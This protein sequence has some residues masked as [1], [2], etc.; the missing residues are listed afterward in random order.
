MP[1]VG[2]TENVIHKTA[3]PA[4]V[5]PAPDQTTEPTDPAPTTPDPKA[6]TSAS[7]APEDRCLDGQDMDAADIDIKTCPELPDAPDSTLMGKT[8]IE[9]G[10]WEIGT[11]STGATY[12]YGTLSGANPR[13]L[14]FEGGSAA[15]NDQ[16]VECWAK[17]YYRLRK[18][19]QTPPAAY[20]ALHKA[21]FQYRFFQFQTDLRNGKTGYTEI[22]SFEDHLVKWVTIVDKTGACKQ[23]TLTQFREYAKGELTTR[24]LPVP[25]D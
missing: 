19:L 17:G 1:L 24:G 12:K 15:V 22:S 10:A 8:T 6:P 3:D 5:A 4:P 16:N 7:K 13:M 18:M 21:K 14:N 23:P 9:L 20:V 2:C 11:T 25:K